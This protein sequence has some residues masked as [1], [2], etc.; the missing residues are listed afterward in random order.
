MLGMV[1][2]KMLMPMFELRILELEVFVLEVLFLLEVYM[3]EML[4]L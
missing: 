1:K 3:P 2:L 4:V